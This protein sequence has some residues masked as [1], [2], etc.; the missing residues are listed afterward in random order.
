MSKARCFARACLYLTCACALWAIATTA[1]KQLLSTVPPLQLLVLQLLPSAVVM[2]LLAVR[3]GT[4]RPA[5]GVWRPL[6]ILG[7]LNPGLS[8]ALSMV[9]LQS[10]T[11]SV[12]TLLW[13][14]EPVLIVVIAW[15]M[16]REPISVRLIGSIG[17]ACVGVVLVTGLLGHHDLE[18][19]ARRGA[20]LIL[21][22][23]ACC[24]VYTVLMRRYAA[25]VDPL[26]AVAIQLGAGL[27]LALTI[28]PMEPRLLGPQPSTAPTIGVVAG[29]AL[30]GLI[31]YAIA[32]WFYIKG[33]QLVPAGVAGLFLN[34][35]PVFGVLLGHAVLGER[36]EAQQLLGGAVILLAVATMFYHHRTEDDT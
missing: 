28:W 26:A 8:Y 17:A 27:A 35:T 24:A 6:A 14:A 34:L 1:S 18:E 33:L 11:V 23:V 25:S 31:Y 12:A 22:G 29:S 5:Q 36:M 2:G 15:A 21:M 3:A 13:A 16:L 9:G 10:S 32:F 4:L 30:C 20:V 19:G 7:A